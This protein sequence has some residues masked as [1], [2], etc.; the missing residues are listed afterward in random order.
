ML[1]FSQRPWTARKRARASALAALCLLAATGLSSAADPV[2]WADKDSR[3]A[4]EYLNLLVEKPEYGRVLELLWDLYD[5]HGATSFLLENIASQAAAQPHPSVLLVHAHLQRKAGNL[6]AAKSRYAEVLKAEPGNTTAIRALA[7][8]AVEQ[9]DQ[10]G[11]LKHLDTLLA[12]YAE[13]DAQRVPILLEQG[14]LWLALSKPEESGARWQQA[15]KLQPGNESLVRDAAQLMLGAGLVDQALLLYHQLAKQTDPA[16]RLDALYDL[17]RLEE[18]VDHFAEASAAL[19]EGLALLH[20]RDWRYAQFFQRLVK[21]HERFGQ[22]DV[23]KA[24]LLKTVQDKDNLQEKT[25]SDLVRY[26]QQTVDQEAQVRWL[27]VLVEQ[28]PQQQDYRWQLVAELLDHDGAAEAATLLDA[29]LREDGTD[30]S[31]ILLM[32]TLAHLRNGE[33]DLAVAR[34]KK[35]LETQGA[36]ADIE[37][38]V[39]AFAREKSL[40]EVTELVLK[41]RIA[42]DGDRPD[43]VFELAVFYRDRGKTKELEQLFQ[44]FTTTANPADKQR[45]LNDVSSFMASGNDPDR[46]E[47]AARLAVAEPGAGREEFLRLADV[48][49]MRGNNKEALSVL[50]KSWILSDNADKRADVDDRIYSVLAGD[51]QPQT[52]PPVEAGSEFKLPAFFTGEGFGTDAPAVTQNDSV[53]DAVTD[54]AL[55]QTLG[56]W[57]KEIDAA[58][59]QTLPKKIQT[60]LTE[61]KSKI[62]ASSP[63]ASP[64]RM[65]RAAWWCWRADQA[66]LAYVLMRRLI[67]DSRGQRAPAPVEVEKLLLDL[68]LSERSVTNPLLASQ[69]LR[70]LSTMD[71]ANRASYQLRLAELEGKRSNKRGLPE[72]V[73][74]LEALAKE[75]PQNEAVLSTLSE[76][77]LEDGKREKALVLWEQSAKKAKGNATPLLERYAELLIAQ[78]KYKEFVETQCRIL[79]MEADVKRRRDLFQRALDRLLWSGS[80]A[81][82]DLF[83]DRGDVTDD[84]RKERLNVMANAL[85]GRSRRNPFDGF[86]HEALAG[87]YEKQGDAAKAFASMKQAYYTA[88]DTPFSLGQLRAAALGVGD[89]KS[90]IYFQKQIAA[91]SGTAEAPGEWR[92]LVQLLEDDFRMKEADQARRRLESRFSQDPVALEELA[93]YY[94][95][96]AQEEAA[97]RVYEQVARVRSWDAANLLRL[98]LQQTGLGD[99]KAAQQTLV[100][101]L[102]ETALPPAPGDLPPEQLPWPLLNERE[103]H[104]AAVSNIIEALDSAPGLEQ[105]VRDAL[106]RFFSLPRPEFAEVPAEPAHVRLRAVEELALMNALP[107][108]LKLS[109]QEAWWAGYYDSNSAAEFRSSLLGLLGKADRVEARFILV[110]LTVKSHGI[111]EAIK[112]VREPNLSATVTQHRKGLFQAVINILADESTFEFTTADVTLLGGAGLLSNTELVDVARKFETRRQFDLSIILGLAAQRNAPSL[113]AD[114]ALFLARMA[115][116]AGDFESQRRY[117]HEVWSKPLEA[118]RPDVFDPFVQSFATLWKTAHT[119]DERERLLTQSLQRLHRLPDSG[120]GAFR[121]GRLLGIV[122]ASEASARK[123]SEY[124]GSGLLSARSFSEPMIGRLP[125]GSPSGPRI[126]EVNRLRSYWED[127]REWEELIKQDGLAWELIGVDEKLSQ[128]NAGTYLGPRSSFE[129]GAWH[130]GT[131][132]RQLKFAT[133]PERILRLREYMQVDGQFDSLLELG[134]L[135]E[136]QGLSRECIEVY[137]NL[138]DRAPTNTEYCEQLL[139]VCE[140]GWESHLAIPYIEKL[141]AAEPQLKPQ[142]ISDETLWEKHARFIARLHDLPRLRTLGFRGNMNLK[143]VPGRVPEEVPYLKELA[144]L[145]ERHG[146]KPGALAAWEELHRLWKED[147]QAGLHRARLLSDQGNKTRALEALRAVSLANFWNEHVRAAFALR[148][149][150][151]AEMGLWDEVRDLMNIVAGGNAGPGAGSGM[152]TGNATP[153]SAAARQSSDVPQTASVLDLSRILASHQRMIEA[154]SLLLRAER[155]VKDDADRFSLRLEQLTLTAADPAWNPAQDMARI[156]SLLRLEVDHAEASERLLAFFAKESEGPRAKFWVQ[157]LTQPAFPKTPLTSVALSGLTPQL[158]PSQLALLAEPWTKG[159]SEKQAARE[160]VVRALLKHGKPQIAKDVALAGRGKGLSDSPVIIPVLAALGDRHCLDEFFAGLVRISFPG[161]GECVAQAEAFTKAGRKELAE[162]L[163]GLALR[164]VRDTGAS[165]P[166]LVESYARFLIGEHRYEEAETILVQDCDGMAET[167]PTLLVDLY[168]A[169]KKL[170]RLEPELVKFHLP[171]GVWHETLFLASQAK[172]K[173]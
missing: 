142:G 71:P 130:N 12:T 69:Q 46:A 42:R 103:S 6:D 65:F 58:S 102:K 92:Q 101:L 80:V 119:S 33:P 51:K 163:Y 48:L 15:V 116:A 83:A 47:K 138:P 112:W 87:I 52:T 84:D 143:P 55:A 79:E 36:N 105:P 24:E 140:N 135:L 136:S 170:D 11:A 128:R 160:Q 164:R 34:L 85:T 88:P 162:E 14:K 29:V 110:W 156:S 35:L 159:E 145:L 23:L 8:L 44:T 30:S 148:S 113:S 93:K 134:G 59:Y 172:P 169:W 28:F 70:R 133:Y 56:V 131:L 147:G 146:D 77:Y 96:S 158:D 121:E 111:Q 1:A 123:L 157:T 63:P 49:A 165:Y 98:A 86:W 99:Q 115:E 91:T 68:A 129:F 132:L 152:G 41:K 18:Q 61:S 114:Y 2:P 150:L 5:K 81:G 16:R 53:P 67:F 82:G 109:G 90:A 60:W 62:P 22:L 171:D 126:D 153:A 127:V 50:E 104:N 118:G 124:M 9:G 125:P 20:F 37:K 106:R 97:R 78:R 19:R 32:R 17:S 120:Q 107:K 141:L 75:D 139:R 100:K 122:G 66:D 76:Y 64:E 151:A 166:A 74:I 73:A 149:K 54:Y 168:G 57:G 31:S 7:D 3:L 40:D 94:A 27:R 38:Q 39:L 13:G 144:L 21:L 4:S 154:Q 167:L 117:L 161:G 137:R 10:A 45:R 43:P 25:L 108:D 173:S 89:L 72:A 155:A 95:G 26:F